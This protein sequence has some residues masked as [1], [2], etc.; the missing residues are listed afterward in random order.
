MVSLGKYYSCATRTSGQLLCWG[1][2]RDGQLGDGTRENRHSPVL[3][4]LPSAVAVLSAGTYHTC[5]V[6]T[7]GKLM[8]WGRNVEGQ[9]GLGTS[10]PDDFHLRPVL[11]DV[12]DDVTAVVTGAEHTCA[13]LVTGELKCFGDNLKQ[14][15]GQK[16]SSLADPTMSALPVTVPLPGPVSMLAV[17]KYSTCAGTDDGAKLV[18][19]GHRLW[20]FPPPDLD[21]VPAHVNAFSTNVP[22]QMYGK[23]T[24]PGLRLQAMDMGGYHVCGVT[25]SSYPSDQVLCF[26]WNSYGQLGDGTTN[27]RPAAVSVAI[28]GEVQLLALG[29]SF[30]CAALKSYSQ[31]I[32]ANGNPKAGQIRCW[33]DNVEGVMGDGT[34]NELPDGWLFNDSHLGGVLKPTPAGPDAQAWAGGNSLVGDSPGGA[35]DPS[36]DQPAAARPLPPAGPARRAR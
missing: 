12:G 5:A 25:N 19:W 4:Q 7:T 3:I 9:L 23:F 1:S 22:A 26:G 11:V 30:S 15:L 27:D 18:C 29:T 33:G 17:G 8:C 34:L 35:A 6:I 16:P 36:P 2:N 21:M 10:G 32:D 24:T 13:A 28:D 20:N 31:E 14:Q